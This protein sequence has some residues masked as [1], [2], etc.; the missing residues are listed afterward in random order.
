[1]IGNKQKEREK[2]DRNYERE[3]EEKNDNERNFHETK[4]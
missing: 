3:E 4:K 2:L 1:M